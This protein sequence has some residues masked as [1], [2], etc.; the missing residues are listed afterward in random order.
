MTTNRQT[1]PVARPIRSEPSAGR[2]VRDF[3]ALG[4]AVIVGLVACVAFLPVD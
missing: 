1:G 3:V 2:P 4:I